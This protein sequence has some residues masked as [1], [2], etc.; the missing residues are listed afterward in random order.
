LLRL[1]AGCLLSAQTPDGYNWRL[2]LDLFFGQVGKGPIFLMACFRH[3]S[4]CKLFFFEIMTS[5]LFR[6]IP[7]QCVNPKMIKAKKHIFKICYWMLIQE[8]VISLLTF[9]PCVMMDEM[10]PT[11][12]KLI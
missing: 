4:H 9:R 10:P 5:L 6:K 2:F 11:L 3:N 1:L 7:V 8:L 12:R